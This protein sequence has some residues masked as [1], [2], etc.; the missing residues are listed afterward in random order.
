MVAMC[1][2]ELA[3]IRSISKK[4]SRYIQE[5]NE[6]YDEINRQEARKE[7]E[8][9]IADKEERE[10]AKQEEEQLEREKAGILFQ[11]IEESLA[12]LTEEYPES[13]IQRIEAIKSQMTNIRENYTKSAAQQAN[14]LRSLY[15]R[16]LKKLLHTVDDWNAL[17][18]LRTQCTLLCN[19]L[20]RSAPLG[21]REMTKNEI[22]LLEK[23]LRESLMLVSL[24]KECIE[25][26]DMLGRKE[27]ESIQSMGKKELDKLVVQLKE[28]KLEQQSRAYIAAA[29][30]ETMREMGYD[31]A[32]SKSEETSQEYLYS[33]HG[34]TLLRVNCQPNGNI[35]MSIGLGTKDTGHELSISEKDGL[36]SDMTTFCTKYE[37]IQNR[38]SEK[39]VRLRRNLVLR[40]AEAKYARTIDISEFGLDS[41]TAANRSRSSKKSQANGRKIHSEE[42]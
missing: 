3:E 15:E 13:I 2:Q 34:S 8:K 14:M 30:E 18:P 36:V 25:L 12:F 9:I 23:E 11:K 39:G 38:L 32:A 22:V 4:L 40:P 16:E 17:E 26:Y 41:L 1:T 10:R 6:R 5:E 19:L 29:V 20:R 42:V 24:R 28:A 21:L 37:E 35:S 31:L 33:V 7:F 27:P